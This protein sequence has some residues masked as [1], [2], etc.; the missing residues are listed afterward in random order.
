MAGMHDRLLVA[1]REWRGG[2]KLSEA[3]AA[4][5]SRYREGRIGGAVVTMCGNGG[6]RSPQY[7]RP[8]T[9]SS[10]GYT[11]LEIL[12]ASAL[13]CIL[14]GISVSS[15]TAVVDRSRGAG[16]ARYLATRAAL[17]RSRAVGR[18]ATVALYFEQDTRG[19]RFSMVE[20]GNG[21]GV[22]TADITQQIDRVIEAPLH[23]SD[24]YP[25]AAIGLVPGTPGTSAV[26]LGGTM[27]LSF[28]PNGTA[29]S[30]SV[31]VVGRDQTQWAVRVLGVTA[32]AR[33]LRYERATGAW[34]NAD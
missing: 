29:T 22:R 32:R 31:Y 13:L 15:V 25:G 21:D 4:R 11:F 19:V 28:S 33:V 17:A 18:S 30:G 20:D 16:A 2:E 6:R 7:P 23:L 9:L 3:E 10:A 14:A 12:F 5:H 24:L 1:A 34:V 26:A 27:I 8:P